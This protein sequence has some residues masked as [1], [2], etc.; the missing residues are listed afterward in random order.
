VRRLL[1]WATAANPADSLA[2]PKVILS[3]G[4]FASGSKLIF[5]LIVLIFDKSA[6][7]VVRPP[8][9]VTVTPK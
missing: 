9:A 8:A 1:L 5:C 6:A 2:P 4:R 3:R 7:E